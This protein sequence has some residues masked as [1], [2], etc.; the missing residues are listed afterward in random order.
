MA[1]QEIALRIDLPSQASLR[2]VNKHFNHTLRGEWQYVKRFAPPEFLN[3]S[4]AEHFALNGIDLLPTLPDCIDQNG[5][6]VLVLYEGE[7]V[8]EMACI[9]FCNGVY[10]IKMIVYDN[11]QCDSDYDSSSDD[12]GDNDEHRYIKGHTSDRHLPQADKILFEKDCNKSELHKILC[13]APF[14]LDCSNHLVRNAFIGGA[15]SVRM[16]LHSKLEATVAD[17]CQSASF[18]YKMMADNLWVH[19]SLYIVFPPEAYGRNGT[20]YRLC[21]D[22]K[23]EYT[24]S[25]DNWT[26]D[27][28]KPVV[29]QPVLDFDHFPKAADQV[30]AHFET[31]T[32]RF[33]Q[34]EWDVVNICKDF[35]K[36]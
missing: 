15:V 10:H 3:R 24:T 29:C 31:G 22:L 9:N 35:C 2:Q 11:Y 26:I 18:C 4:Q 6:Q 30:I 5:S 33:E 32:L 25:S 20:C 23:G 7:E 16:E 12:S 8:S 28:Y 13:N 19:A 14:R 17:L 27:W 1:L 36:V 21:R 34:A